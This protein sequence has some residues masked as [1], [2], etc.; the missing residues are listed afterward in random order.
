MDGSEVVSVS[1]C[2]VLDVRGSTPPQYSSIVFLTSLLV[3]T[4][5][6][7]KYLSFTRTNARSSDEYVLVPI[8]YDE[9]QF[10]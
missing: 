10:Y 8:T 2:G 3:L 4:K 7:R 1:S 6:D 9:V 5:N